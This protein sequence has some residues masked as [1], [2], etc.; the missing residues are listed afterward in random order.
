LLGV[1]G[2]RIGT[3]GTWTMGAW[4]GTERNPLV[5][6]TGD[7]RT[8]ALIQDRVG[9]ELGATFVATRWAAIGVRLPV[10]VAQRRA[11][12][13][14]GVVGELGELGGGIGDVAV[15]PKIALLTQEV[16]AFDL[17]V[18]ATVTLPT[19]KADEYL[20]EGFTF[21]PAIAAG[22]RGQRVRVA[23][24]V[25]YLVRGATR[26]GSTT[27]DDEVFA[28]GGAAVAI[29]RVEVGATVSFATRV[30]GAMSG[31]QYL[32]VVGGPSVRVGESTTAFAAGGVGL[33]D[34]FGTPDWR[35]LAGVRYELR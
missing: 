16:S 25:G 32:E 10:V 14:E 22:W 8:G 30:Q 13:V 17:A 27:I 21:A 1:E 4:M 23:G 9:G 5:V 18:L 34:A 2:A 24:E 7:E 28:R 19:G 33:D 12:M 26:I 31:Y 20:R 15:S 3:P 35:A 29:D 6:R 11:R